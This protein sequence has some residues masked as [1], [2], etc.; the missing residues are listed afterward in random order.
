MK[1][2]KQ[3]N[4]KRIQREDFSEEHML[5]DIDWFR[6]TEAAANR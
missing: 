2:K 1:R 3:T 4:Y 6:A 5:L